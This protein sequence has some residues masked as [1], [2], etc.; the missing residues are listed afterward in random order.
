MLPARLRLFR[1][2]FTVA[3]PFLLCGLL[4]LVVVA[5]EADEPAATPTPAAKFETTGPWGKLEYYQIRLEPPTSQMRGALLKEHTTWNF[6]SLTETGV[7]AALDT[8]GFSGEIMTLL[9]SG[10]TWERGKNGLLLSVPDGVIEGLTPENRAALADWFKLHNTP[11]HNQIVLN[12]EGGDF[13]AFDGGKVSAET[14][15]AVKS[16]SFLRNG[17]LSV[18]DLPYLMKKI[19]N[20]PEEKEHFVRAIFSTRSLIVRLVIDETT[21]T[22]SVIDYWSQAGRISR[23]ES[24]VRGVEMTMGVDKIDIVHLLPPLARRYLYAFSNLSDTGVNNTPDCFWAS[25]HFFK[26][27]PSPRV[28]DALSFEHYLERDFT[29]IDGELRFGDL[30]CL[31]RP[32]DNSFLHSYVHIADDIVFT[33]NGASSVHPFILTLKSDMMSRYLQEGEFTTKVY[34]R[35]PDS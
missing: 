19:G 4:G 31:L 14:L 20:N 8:I 28:L 22:Q 10:G 29:E 13:S 26:R 15:A 12:I 23:V 16:L 17:V 11:F 2:P 7:L 6:G 25:I 34:R 32:A 24:M 27:N 33:K 3:A 5:M 35:N 9:E 30:V 21:D 1:H 18:M